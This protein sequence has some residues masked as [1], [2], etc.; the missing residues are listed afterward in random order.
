MKERLLHTLLPTDI[1]KST[2][3]KWNKKHEHV[4][5]KQFKIKVFKLIYI[6]DL[7]S[8]SSCVHGN[9]LSNRA[10]EHNIITLHV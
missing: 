4:F 10:N 2:K 5:K 9:D 3:A 8:S 1:N 6:A 7:S